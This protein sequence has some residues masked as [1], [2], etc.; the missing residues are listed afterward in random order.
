MVAVKK[1]LER[2]YTGLCDVYE[3][4]QA[5]D[6]TTKVTKTTEVKVLT[7]QPCRLSFKQSPAATQTEA[8]ANLSQ[9]IT[10]FL[11]PAPVIKTGSKIIVTQSGRTEVFKSSGHPA[12]HTNHQE[13]TLIRSDER[14]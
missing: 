6:P 8:A 5:K 1:A 14:A 11:D 7:A 2:L 13:I 9:T 4:T 10:L 3:F 12:V